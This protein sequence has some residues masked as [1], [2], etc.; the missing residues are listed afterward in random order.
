MITFI[1]FFRKSDEFT[2]VTFETMASD[3]RFWV[4]LHQNTW[5]RKWHHGTLGGAGWRNVR[6]VIVQRCT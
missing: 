6:P 5:L 2:K 4:D 1:Q 3:L